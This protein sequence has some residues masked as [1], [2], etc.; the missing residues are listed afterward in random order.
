MP[1]PDGRLGVELALQ[2]LQRLLRLLAVLDQEQVVLLDLHKRVQDLL[3][4]R[5]IH[6]HD[7]SSRSLL[8]PPQTHNSTRF[9]STLEFGL[10][11]LNPKP[12]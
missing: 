4:L 6:R 8:E 2:L 1:E 3:R 7:V 11:D 10:E 9:N 5:E 12:A